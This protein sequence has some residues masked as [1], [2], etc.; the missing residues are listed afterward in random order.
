MSKEQIKA[1]A[2]EFVDAY[3]STKEREGMQSVGFYEDL[4]TLIDQ[5]IADTC[6]E[7][8]GRL[9]GDKEV[10]PLHYDSTDAMKEPIARANGHNTYRTHTLEVIA[11]V[12]K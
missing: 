9:M 8:E 10:N 5:T 4:D 6:A 12:K 7:I 2:R 3:L 1:K 11:Y